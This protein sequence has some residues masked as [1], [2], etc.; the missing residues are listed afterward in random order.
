MID[1]QHDYLVSKPIPLQPPLVGYMK[2][3]STMRDV[4]RAFACRDIKVQ[5]IFSKNWVLPFNNIITCFPSSRK[6][7]KLWGRYHLSPNG[8]AQLPK[9]SYN[10]DCSC[11][12][13]FGNF[14]IKIFSIDTYIQ[15]Y[16]FFRLQ[17]HVFIVSWPCTAAWPYT[18]LGMVTKSNP[19]LSPNWVHC[20]TYMKLFNIF[21]PRSKRLL[22]LS[23]LLIVLLHVCM[24]MYVVKILVQ[25]NC[26]LQLFYPMPEVYC[27]LTTV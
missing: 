8:S 15:W 6:L 18:V 7:N 5:T 2:S 9:E 24:C 13:S 4:M 17:T 26:G 27:M 16:T 22:V 11:H 12:I 14:L 10:N 3:S 19:L 20:V 21:F 1:D 23:V 25:L